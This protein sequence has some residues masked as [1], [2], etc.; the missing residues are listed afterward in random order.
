MELQTEA[1]FKYF[2]SWL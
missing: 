1:Q 2:S